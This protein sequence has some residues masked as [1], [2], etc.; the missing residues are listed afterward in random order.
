MKTVVSVLLFCCGLL[1]Q[2]APVRVMFVGDIMLD[3]GP[4]HLITN[5]EDPFAP[6]AAVL[7]DADITVGN[8][9]C[10]IT[11]RGHWL[12]KPYVFK[13]PRA[14]LPLLKKYFSAVSLANNHSGDW[15]HAGFA[16]ELALLRENGVAFFGGGDNRDAAA[17]PLIL[18]R[19]GK[20]VALLA[21]CDYPPHSFA[22]TASRP[23]TAWLDEKRVIRAIKDARRQVDFVLLYL[24]WGI[25]L[26]DQPESYQPPL[27]RRLIDAG[28]DAVIGSH[29]HV[30]QTIEW[31]RGKPIIY[32]LGNFLF[33]YFPNDPRHWT[34]WMARLTLGAADGIGLEIYHIEMDASGVAHLTDARPER[35]PSGGLERPD[36]GR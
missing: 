14:A 8:L 6:T 15:G 27:A 31:Y 3:Y 24:H 4:G 22:A 29:P 28:A 33:D 20:R 5:G 1:A 32:S 17:R 26:E 19:N 12:D 11:R 9:E 13:G 25:E 35:I 10:A 23:G 30:T 34:A 2:S 36:R 18:E 16:D 7:R 21:F